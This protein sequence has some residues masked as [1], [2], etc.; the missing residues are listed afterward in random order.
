MGEFPSGQR[1][2]TVNL[3][4]MPSVVRIHLLPPKNRLVKASRFFIH[5]ESNGISSA[6]RLYI[7]N[8]G[9]AVVVS[10]HAQRVSKSF[11]NDDIQCSALIFHRQR[12][13]ITKISVKVDSNHR[14]ENNGLI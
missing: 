1:G 14:S 13:N 10:H 7:I 3:L 2:Q 9:K 6:V 12:R 8:N 11:R 4:A 5:C